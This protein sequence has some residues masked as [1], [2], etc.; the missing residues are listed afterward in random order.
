MGLP[1]PGQVDRG[2]WH[3]V[4][5]LGVT[6]IVSWGSLYYAFAVVMDAVRH[7][8]QASPP[9]IVG[10]YSVALLVSGLVAAPVGRHIDRH[11]ARRAMTAGSLGAVLLLAAFSQVTSAAALYGVWAALGAMMGLTLYEPAFAS[12]AL[13]FRADLRKAITVLTLAGGF[14]STVF[15]PL[16]QW[17]AS[18]L[19]WREAVLVLAAINLAVCVPLHALYLPAKGRPAEAQPGA[20]DDPAGRARLLADRHFRWLAFAFTLNMLAFSAMGLHLLAMLQEQGF[21]P[22][23]AA[24]LAALVGPMQV[25]GRIVEFAFAHRVSPARVGEIA[26]FLFP[27]SIAILAFAG[28]STMGVV[29]FAVLYGASN[30]VMTIVRGTVPAE[31]WGRDGYG[32][33]TGLMATPVL[34]A[35]AAGPFAAAAILAF[36]GGY[37]AVT[38]ALIAV[39]VCFLGRVRGGRAQQGRGFLG[40]RAQQLDDRWRRTMVMLRTLSLLSPG[41]AGGSGACAGHRRAADAFA[42]QKAAHGDDRKGAAGERG[43]VEEVPGQRGS[44]WRP[45]GLQEVAAQPGGGRLLPGLRPSRR[46][47]RGTEALGQVSRRRGRGHLVG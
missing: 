40:R 37:H 42:R 2:R 47:E 24:L 45:P 38:L 34:I 25:A 32:G 46:C 9:V 10:A 26:L 43:S 33:L 41:Y 11:G 13:V 16:T 18:A 4:A 21:S 39:G 3:V 8:L 6:Q 20:A 35:R 7:E 28:G 27:V 29:V 12:L 44:G 31:I 17:L 22:E 15:W 30:G 19:G 14:A 23:K 5:A 36:A 1:D